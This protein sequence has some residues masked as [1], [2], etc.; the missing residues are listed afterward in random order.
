MGVLAGGEG[1]EE[2]EDEE[3]DEGED[4][5]EARTWTALRGGR[6]R[7]LFNAH[8]AAMVDGRAGVC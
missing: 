3:E 6:S 5:G 2:D 4:K 8:C 1:E 7:S